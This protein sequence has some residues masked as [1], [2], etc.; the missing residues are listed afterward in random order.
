LY[1]LHG[2]NNLISYPY[3]EE[4]YIG[5]ALPDNMEGEIY[6]IVGEGVAALNLNNNWLG[7]LQKFYPGNGY[8]FARSAHAENIEFS[9]EAPENEI[10]VADERD[11]NESSVIPVEYQYFQSTKQGFYFVESLSIEEELIHNENWIIAYNNDTVVGA[12]LWSGSF[13]DVPAMGDEGSLATVGYMQTGNIPSF[14]LLN[15]YTGVLTDLNI[16]NE[17]AAWDDN[18]IHIIS[19]TTEAQL[20]N[21]ITLNAAYPNPFNPSTTISFSIPEDMSV[22]L[23]VYDIS[24]RVVTELMSGIQ[25]ADN[26]SVNWDAD[27]FSSGIYLVQLMAGSE[28]HTQKIMLIK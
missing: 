3:S 27:N 13:T 1:T 21:E 10:H 18:R 25:S 14:K 8:W 24:G 2:A 23:K 17:I 16:E 4:Q 5:D 9:Y 28:V 11:F 7:S 15:A 26:Y 6:A 12:R 20:P 19:L 22:D